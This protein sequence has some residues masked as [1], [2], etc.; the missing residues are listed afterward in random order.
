MSILADCS[1]A[2]DPTT[3]T[4]IPRDSRSMYRLLNDFVEKVPD[5]ENV[6][7]S[8]LVNKFWAPEHGDTPTFP[9]INGMLLICEFCE[10]H[11]SLR[12]RELEIMRIIVS[13]D[14]RHMVNETLAAD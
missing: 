8:E 4:F 3:S 1:L 9:L 13:D 6:Q 5:R 12:G 14:D 11:P 2:P 7:T 10:K